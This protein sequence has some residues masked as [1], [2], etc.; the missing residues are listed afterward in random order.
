MSDE[1]TPPLELIR[2]A[3]INFEN[4]EK[5]APLGSIHPFYKIAKRQLDEGLK[6]MEHGP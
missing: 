1:T 5:A 4:F 6:A 3:Q 2:S